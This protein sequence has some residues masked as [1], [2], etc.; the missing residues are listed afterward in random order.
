MR[1][2]KVED[3]LAEGVEA[4][5]GTCEKFVTPGKRGPPD[6]IISWPPMS[7]GWAQYIVCYHGMNWSHPRIP[8]VEFVETKTPTDEKPKSWQLRDHDRR[9]KMGFNVEV[10]ACFD[11]V[12]DYLKR[13]GKK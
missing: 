11:H 13:R 7:T 8:I 10:H 3:R 1:E 9:R 5:G 2:Y 12:D 6:R 4:L